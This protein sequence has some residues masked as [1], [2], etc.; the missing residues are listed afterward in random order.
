M[1]CQKCHERE[2]TVFISQTINQETT[3][4]H[5]CAQCAAEQGQVFNAGPVPLHPFGDFGDFLNEIVQQ[6]QQMGEQ[7]ANNISKDPSLMGRNAPPPMPSS[8]QNGMPVMVPVP[9]AGPALQCPHCGYQFETFRQTGRL[10]CTRCYES[11]A[12]VLQPLIAG[13]HGNLAHVDEGP[14]PGPPVVP[15]PTDRLSELKRKLKEAVQHEN[16]EEAA[17]LRDEIHSLEGNLK[18]TAKN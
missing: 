6:A 11:F 13:I 12:Q 15:E 10:G 9:P 17:K 5:L 4:T 8:A 1:I 3:Q 14:P 18:G 7:I 2:A 16:F